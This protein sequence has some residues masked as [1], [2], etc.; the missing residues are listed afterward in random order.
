MNPAPTETR[1]KNQGIEKKKI[2]KAVWFITLRCNFKC[3]Y[4]H[5]EQVGGG[6]DGLDFELNDPPL[7]MVEGAYKYNQSG[8]L[9]GT[10]KVGGWNHFGEAYGDAQAVA[11]GQASAAGKS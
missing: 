11:V 6:N 2:V 4:C 5:A 8:R 3:R 7:L 1:E 9:P 10:V